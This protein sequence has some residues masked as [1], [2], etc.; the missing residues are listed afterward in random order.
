MSINFTVNETVGKVIFARVDFPAGPFFPA[1]L[2]VSE[3]II[4]AFSSVQ[5]F[6]PKTRADAV[7]SGFFF[8]PRGGCAL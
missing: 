6:G 8:S 2:I 7:L 1:R 5:Y 3:L 4:Y